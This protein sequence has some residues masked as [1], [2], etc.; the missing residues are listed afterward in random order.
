MEIRKLKNSTWKPLKCKEDARVYIRKIFLMEL[1]LKNGRGINICWYTSSSDEKD[2]KLKWFPSSFTNHCNTFFLISNDYS[3]PQKHKIWELRLWNIAFLG[4][5]VAKR[6]K[7]YFKSVDA[8]ADIFVT[9]DEIYHFL[10]QKKNVKS[11]EIS[12]SFRQ[13]Y[14]F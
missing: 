8:D 6:T 11:T 7:I 13:K 9:S 14:D 12:K 1:M 3:W 10:R 4:D 5:V 2:F